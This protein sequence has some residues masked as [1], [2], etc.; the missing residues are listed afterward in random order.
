MPGILVLIGI[1]VLVVWLSRNNEKDAVDRQSASYR[2]GYWDGVRAAQ[3]GEVT[4]LENEAALVRADSAVEQ[5]FITVQETLSPSVESVVLPPPMT[6]L[7]SSEDMP[8]SPSV[9]APVTMTPEQQREK[10]RQTTINIALYAASLLLVAGIVLLVQTIELMPSLRF[11]LVWLMIFVYYTAGFV[12]YKHTPIVKPA[13][14]AF[15]GTALAALPLGG[16]SFS[17]FLGVDPALC[18][19]VTSLL[20]AGLFVAATIRLNSQFLAYIS[21]LSFFVFGAS[22]PAVMGSQLV[23]Y[24]VVLIV[25]GAV[26][27]VLS[28]LFP[29]ALHQFSEPVSYGGMIAVPGA[30]VLATISYGLLSGMEYSAML[31]ASTLYYVVA[32]V[33]DTSR[34]HRLYEIVVARTLMIATVASFASYF[35]EGNGTIVSVTISTAALLNAIVSIY[36]LVP[37]RQEKTHHDISLWISF[38]AALIA[39]L[40]VSGGGVVSELTLEHFCLV[41]S[42]EYALLLLVIMASLIRLRRIEFG[43]FATAAVTIL[44]LTVA[45][46]LSSVA[47]TR[48]NWAFAG[49]VIAISFVVLLRWGALQKNALS[50]K[51]AVL[52]YGSIGVWLLLALLQVFA[53]SNELLYGAGLA[54]YTA[55][56]CGF[57]VWRERINMFILG[58]QALLLMAVALVGIHLYVN[59]ETILVVL[60]WLNAVLTLLSV[61]CFCSRSKSNVSIGSLLTHSTWAY[62]FLIACG[63]TH[64][65]AWLPL[66]G[67]L[68][69]A[70]YRERSQGCFAL[71]NGVVVAFML[72]FGVWIHLPWN[73]NLTLTAWMSLIGFG[74]VYRA[75]VKRHETAGLIALGSATIPAVLFGLIVWA[76][77]AQP[78]LTVVSWIALVAALYF[79]VYERRLNRPLVLLGVSNAS[80]VALCLLVFR[81]AG[82]NFFSM[83][84]FVALLSLI[85]FYQ[86]ALVVR[87]TAEYK[88]WSDVLFWSA[89]GWSITL[90]LMALTDTALLAETIIAGL[91]LILTSGALLVEGSRV[92]PARLWYFDAAA[93]VAL[94][95]MTAIIVRL[96]P[97]VHSL[98][99]SH[100]WAMA[101]AVVAALYWRYRTSA[102]SAT[103]VH[104]VIAL[105]IL[106]VPTFSTA[107]FGDIRG[108]DTQL[109]AQVLFLAE[110]AGLVVVGMALGKRLIALW[111]AVG[112][113]FAI[114]FLLSGYTYLLSIAIGLLIIGA[115]VYAIVRDNKKRKLL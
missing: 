87:R 7:E 24:Y 78:W 82:L 17:V 70:A 114:L 64:P 57:I 15:I 98:V 36:R 5:P 48:A 29:K 49:Y 13:A 46:L 110:H 42:I 41:V 85:V 9:I 92:K 107:L 4:D 99:I 88:D 6:I 62:G 28:R 109:V 2:Q 10:N 56:I 103:T 108:S 81:W 84:P 47:E 66:A 83:A 75:I 16:I 31:L 43:Y 12:L 14:V 32:G 102:T 1:V 91:T 106:S 96:F 95:G 77:D 112:V 58:T 80:F 22:I 69:Y 34:T 93:L 55:F 67:A 45:E 68:Y 115:V 38:G 11:A 30:V 25:F 113:T 73:E 111:G 76:N 27:T 59:H 79:V 52:V 54:L 104:I 100:L 63:T 26:L 89:A 18:W 71:A 65:A 35:S 105:L 23:W 19:A 8:A 50:T 3:S 33:T 37:H 61:Q 60:A 72:L 101:A 20:G 94:Q 97:G 51:Q 86:A 44:P 21:L 40:W 39:P 53:S 90:S 74:A